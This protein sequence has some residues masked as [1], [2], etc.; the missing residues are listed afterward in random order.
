[1]DDQG[2]APPK[3]GE[4]VGVAP[5][6]SED[7]R[8]AACRANYRAV[9]VALAARQAASGSGALTVEELARDGWLDSSIVTSDAGI[10]LEVLNSGAATGRILV[11]GWA[12]R[13]GTS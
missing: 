2:V 8:N 12:W 13:I 4:A 11:D 5:R 9:E 6:S 1:M 7:A 3:E 10:T